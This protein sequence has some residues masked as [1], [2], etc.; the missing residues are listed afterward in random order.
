MMGDEIWIENLWLNPDE[1][2]WRKIVSP[3][4]KKSN[5]AGDRAENSDDGTA[6]FRT[7]T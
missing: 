2:S 5:Y 7:P 4:D 3:G 1:L 6:D